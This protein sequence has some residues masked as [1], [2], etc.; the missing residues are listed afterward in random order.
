MSK[1]GFQLNFKGG[2]IPKYEFINV[3]ID[4]IGQY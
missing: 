1:V 2:E 4:Q 3:K